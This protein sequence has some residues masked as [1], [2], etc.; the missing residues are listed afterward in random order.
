MNTSAQGDRQRS[1]E[2]GLRF[3]IGLGAAV[4]VGWLA[5]GSASPEEPCAS[6]LSSGELLTNVT[7]RRATVSWI[8][9]RDGEFRIRYAEAEF[10]GSAAEERSVRVHGR[11]GELSEVELGPLDPG[12]AY[13][14]RLGCANASTESIRERPPRNFRTLRPPGEPVSFAFLTDSHAYRAWARAQVSDAAS[15]QLP[16]ATLEQTLDNVRERNLDFMILGGDEVMTHCVNCARV[17]LGGEDAGRNTVRTLRQAELRYLMWRRLYEAAGRGLPLFLVLGN[18]DGEAGF[19]NAEGECSHYPDTAALS[20][21]ARKG[22]L[23]DPLRSYS[24]GNEGGYYSF[25]SGDALFVILDVMSGPTEYPRTPD[26]WTLGAKQLAWLETVLA[27]SDE[28]WKFL[29]AHHIVGGDPRPHCYAY[30]RGGV[31]ATSNG[32]AD[33]VF[34]GEQALIHDLMRRYA[35]QFFLYGHDHIFSFAEKQNDRGA[36]EGIFYVAGGQ[37]SLNP[38]SWEDSPW[39]QRL[40]DMDGD[41]K[42]DFLPEPGFLSVS[43]DGDRSVRFQYVR[44]DP[45]HPEHNKRIDFDRR[46]GHERRPGAGRVGTATEGS[47]E[48]AAAPST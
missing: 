32:R 36:G 7:T 23:P 10:V 46:I 38:S 3:A 40:Y 44:S 31:N 5:C 2:A 26:D 21:R 14:Y 42:G 30:G 16:L 39:F 47:S 9:S 11:A 35:A 41:A 27:G 4:S 8:P 12:V 18:H 19:G 33:G 29:F 24:G 37:S 1:F 28:T 48:S 45:S 22:A 43:V 17:D 20:I 34:N 25:V 6:T 13:T 15:D